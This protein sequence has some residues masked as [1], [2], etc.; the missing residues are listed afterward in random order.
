MT[1]GKIAAQCGCVLASSFFCVLDFPKSGS[2]SLPSHCTDMP[3]LLVTKRWSKRIQ[4]WVSAYSVVAGPLL[5][6]FVQAGP[7]LGSDRVKRGPTLSLWCRLT[8]DTTKPSQNRV[9]GLIR[10]RDP[11]TRGY[12]EELESLR[13]FHSGRVSLDATFRVEGF[14]LQTVSE[15]GRKSKPVRG[16]CSVLDLVGF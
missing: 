13:A 5:S 10:G 15:E 7:S 2:T 8:L 1:P 4:K 12:R 16:L 11:G 6:A 14:F 3:R 9:E